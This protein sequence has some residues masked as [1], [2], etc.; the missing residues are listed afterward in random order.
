[1]DVRS[2]CHRALKRSD[3]GHNLQFFT[4]YRII[5]IYCWH[6]DSEQKAIDELARHNLQFQFYQSN[7]QLDGKNYEQFTE[8]FFWRAREYLAWQCIYPEGI[9]MEALS[10]RDVNAH[11]KNK[12]PASKNPVSKVKASQPAKLTGKEKDHPPPPPAE[13]REPPSS[14]RKYGAIYETGKCLGKGGFAICYEGTLA[15][16][17]KKYALKIVKSHM[18]QKKMEQKVNGFQFS[19]GL[20]D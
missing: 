13:V 16:A 6:N 8:A 15:G 17:K 1:L 19:I 3:R 14:G 20:R 18:P 2:D 9:D 10:P 5:Q 12:Q 11:I 7:H 4:N